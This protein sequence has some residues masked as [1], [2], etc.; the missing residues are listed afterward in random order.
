VYAVGPWQSSRHLMARNEH[1]V[2]R[3]AGYACFAVAIMQIF[4]YG[5]GGLIN[6]ANPDISPPETVMIWAAKNLVPPFLGALLLAGI[7]AAALSSASTFLSL[8]GFS[9]SN[10]MVKRK[11]ELTVRYTRIVM[12]VTGAVVLIACFIFPPN[13]FWLM[14]F[15]G[16]VFASS[17]GPVGFMSIW[18]KR[19]TA[20]AAF[21]GIVTGFVCNVVPAALVYLGLIELPSYLNPALIGATISFLTIFGVSKMG[22]VTEQ[23]AQYRENLHR[24]PDDDYD[25]KKTKTT[26]LAPAFLIAYGCLMPVLLINYYVLPYQTGTGQL[27]ADGSLDWSTGGMVL[28]MLTGPVYII[29]GLIVARVVWSRYSPLAK[30]SNRRVDYVA[31]TETA[32]T[33]AS[34]EAE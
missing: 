14:L 22:T 21:W 12:L 18:S 19:I 26:M 10:D 30:G 25:L 23:E 4:I 1:V 27:L 8:V 9:V 2:I 15:I 34:S 11:K 16:T 32:S 24:T 28:A 17:W 13:V 6:V 5:I 7:M 31:D 3:A 20:D 33:Y 29:L